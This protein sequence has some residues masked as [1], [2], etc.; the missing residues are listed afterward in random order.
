MTKT[1]LLLSVVLGLA[2]SAS[3]LVPREDLFQKGGDLR[4]AVEEGYGIVLEVKMGPDGALAAETERTLDFLPGGR[5]AIVDWQTDDPRS[6]DLFEAAL[7][8]HPAIF[9]KCHLYVCTNALA[10][11]VQEKFI[12]PRHLC[13]YGIS[14]TAADALC[15]HRRG[16]FGIAVRDA[17][18]VHAEIAAIESG[19]GGDAALSFAHAIDKPFLP[20]N[21]ANSSQASVYARLAELDAAADSKWRSLASRTEYDVYRRELRERMLEAIG[22]FPE[23]TPLGFRVRRTVRY[24]GF[25]VE[26]VTFESMPGLIVPA[27]LYVPESAAAAHPRPAVVI[28]CGHGEM[29][30]AKYVLAAKELVE[31]GLVAFIFEA[32]EQGERVEYPQY[33]CCQNHNLIGLK[34]MLLGSSM[35]ALRIWDGLRAVDC[36]EA[37]PYV[38]RARIGYMGQ[39]G[40]GTMTALMTAVDLRLKATAPSGYL[41]NFGYLCKTIGPQDAEQNIFGQLAFG[42]NHTG[43]VLIPDTKVLVT[44]KFDDFFAYGGTV[45]MMETVKSVAGMLGE[46]DHYSMNFAPGLHGWAES[47]LRGSAIWMSAWLDGRKDLLPLDLPAQRFSDFGFDIDAATKGL[48]GT[49]AL[50]LGGTSSTAVPGARSI[51]DILRDRFSAAR[52]VRT[53]R[54]AD[55]TASR[56]RRLAAILLPRETNVRVKEMAVE[57][58]GTRRLTRLAFVYPDGFALPAVLIERTDIPVRGTPVLLAGSKG[59]LMM[60]TAAET[61]LAEGRTVLVCDVMGTGEV[62]KTDKIH[63]GA[64]DTPEEGVS[65]MLYLMGESMVGRRATDLLVFADWLVKRTGAPVSLRADGSVAIAAAHAFAAERKLFSD[66]KVTNA[67]PSWT[68]FLEKPGAPMPYRYTWCVNGA[69][70]EYDWEDLLK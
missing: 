48:T 16:E 36:M 7:K 13:S 17:A 47:T 67:P 2:V 58:V 61:A 32:Y 40:G 4:R 5:K 59:R 42:L 39:S 23:R 24:D 41:T 20:N 10:Q 22:P 52:Q 63:Y 51:H 19:K 27:C 49:D 35:A 14:E 31:R 56:V 33:N 8:R 68:A 21:A 15:R 28:S 1:G 66:V 54:T 64:Y 69:L 11:R 60:R 30:Y 57:T 3:A 45:Q 62:I 55:E 50:V 18:K 6:L 44:G 38:D 26:Y 34:A 37:L 29:N 53:A 43:Y 46:E 9:E 25:R 70:C 65:I 12:W